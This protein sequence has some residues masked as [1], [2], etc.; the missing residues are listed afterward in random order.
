MNNDDSVS[1]W[2]ELSKVGDPQA[3]QAIWERFFPKLVALAQ[4]RLRGE[5]NRVADE[6]D[7]VLS[8]FESYFRAAAADRFPDLRDRSNLWRLLSKMT[9]RKVVDHV[10][11][12]QRLKRQI[13]G[14]SAIPGF[15][16]ESRDRNLYE[17]ID[18]HPQPD[19]EFIFSE[20]CRRLL[21]MLSERLR[22]TAEKKLEGYLN[23][24]I[25]DVHGCS[26]ATVERQLKMIREIWDDEVCES[27]RSSPRRAKG[28]SA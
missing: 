11:H 26:V 25:A 5:R 8:V 18:P 19:L 16:G 21:N 20:E 6:E 15:T 12:S 2:I 27:A 10:R 28:G 14:E 9:L 17:A 24:E 23:R 13:D 22:S 3:Q 4:Q 1:V 7:V